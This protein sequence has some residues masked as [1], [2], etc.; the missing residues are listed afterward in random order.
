MIYNKMTS[1]DIMWVEDNMKYL[2]T[3]ISKPNEFLNELIKLYNRIS[4]KNETLTGCSVCIKN[5][6]DFILN[7]YR[8]R[9][10]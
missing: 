1:M 10:V 2:T 9:E 4:G 5:M 3:N 8:H 6:M 7:Q